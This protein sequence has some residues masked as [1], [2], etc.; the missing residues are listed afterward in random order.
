MTNSAD[1][2]Q[3]VVLIY[4]VCKGRAYL[5]SAGSGLTSPVDQLHCVLRHICQCIRVTVLSSR[6]ATSQISKLLVNHK[7]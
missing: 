1:P 6:L 4:T 3:L 7:Y 2:D 5:G